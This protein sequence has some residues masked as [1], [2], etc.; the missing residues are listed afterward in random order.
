MYYSELGLIMIWY[1]S[2]SDLPYLWYYYVSILQ[3]ITRSTSQ[4]IYIYLLFST[5]ILKNFILQMIIFCIF[6][7]IQHFTSYYEHKQTDYFL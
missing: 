7:I 4:S 3:I 1:I 5:S 6:W 2:W